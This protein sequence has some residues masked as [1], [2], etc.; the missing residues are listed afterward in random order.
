MKRMNSKMREQ[1]FR[2]LHMAVDVADKVDNECYAD[3]TTKKM[4]Y[5]RLMLKL[6]CLAANAMGI[7]L[8]NVSVPPIPCDFIGEG[9]EDSDE[10]TSDVSV[11]FFLEMEAAANK[12]LHDF[13]M[14]TG[15][16][17]HIYEEAEELN[18][19]T[20]SELEHLSGY[21]S[22]MINF[23]EEERDVGEPER[24]FRKRCE[25]LGY[26]SDFEIQLYGAHI[27]LL[28]NPVLE[29]VY[30][31]CQKHPEYKEYGGYYQEI[32]KYVLDMRLMGRY[33]PGYEKHEFSEKGTYVSCLCGECCMSGRP[34]VSSVF[35]LNY[36]Y[37]L[38]LGMAEMAA[39]DLLDAVNANQ[40]EAGHAA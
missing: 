25:N 28:Q 30:Q 9:E 23:W 15:W 3:L 29:R 19:L 33:F 14:A 7:P 38:M 32:K 4:V 26:Y 10:E 20:D 39:M 40:E 21:L 13:C 1:F 17:L 34:E 35:F 31:I 2:S 12:F 22:T 37:V 8:E 6:G 36:L 18:P 11:D 5:S 27:I 24:R 16:E